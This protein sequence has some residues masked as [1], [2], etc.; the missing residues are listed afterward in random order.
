[1]TT[2]LLTH[3]R[4]AAFPLYA[5]L[6]WYRN[7]FISR[8]ARSAVTFLFL[9][10]LGSV[11]VGYLAALFWSFQLGVAIHAAENAYAEANEQYIR[12]ALGLEE[13]ERLLAAGGENGVEYMEKVAEISY[14][15]P[16]TVAAVE[17]LV[18]PYSP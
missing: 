9:A 10:M 8:N 11:V 15:E 7:I 12:A 18:Y 13:R 6:A 17:R 16:S 3:K 4:V 2:L 1:M 5:R 14:V